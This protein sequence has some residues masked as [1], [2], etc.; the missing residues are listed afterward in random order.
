MMCSFPEISIVM[1]VY[2]GVADRLNETVEIALG[3]GRGATGGLPGSL[4]PGPRR[5][6]GHGGC[7]AYSVRLGLIFKP[8]HFLG[9]RFTG[10]IL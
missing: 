3:P 5:C 8:D 1:S 7:G 10:A 6:N 4:V 9:S 2:N